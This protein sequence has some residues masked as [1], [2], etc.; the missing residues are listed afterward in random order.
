MKVKSSIEKLERFIVIRSDGKKEEHIGID[1]LKN[2]EKK[3]ICKK[4]IFDWCIKQSFIE[5][6]PFITGRTLKG[7]KDCFGFY[8][9]KYNTVYNRYFSDKKIDFKSYLSKKIIERYEPENKKTSGNEFSSGK[10]YSV[11]SSSRFVVSSFTEN[12][13]KE[14]LDYIR[15]IKINGKQELIKFIEFEHDTEV[16]AN[17]FRTP[18]LDVYFETEDN[19]VYF[20]EAKCHEIFESHKLIKIS[21]SYLNT[22]SFKELG[23]NLEIICHAKDN[24]GKEIHFAFEDFGCNGIT[25]FHFDTK[26]FLCHLMGILTYARRTDNKNKKIH[27]Y[28]LFFKNNFYA[29]NYNNKIYK[30]LEKEVKIIFAVFREKFPNI[31]FGFCYNDKYCTLKELKS[32]F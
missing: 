13:T 22:E 16:D 19:N 8:I 14:K 24:S 31:D 1:L 27:F 28:Y 17:L 30:E 11:A 9:S 5:G 26:Q 18:K 4:H 29:E 12:N 10:F 7:N 6:N 21:K 25:T 32:E 20:I 15:T 2:A 23:L 3:D